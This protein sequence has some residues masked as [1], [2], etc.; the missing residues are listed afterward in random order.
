[1]KRLAEQYLKNWIQSENRK[2]LVLRGARQV[3]KSTLVRL[4]SQSQKLNLVEINLEKKKLKSIQSEDIFIE[5]VLAEIQAEYNVDIDSNSLVFFDEIQTQPEILKFLRYFYEEIPQIPIIAAGSL[6][7]FTLEEHE[8]SMPVGRV[9]YFHLGPMTF[10][11]FLLALNKSKLVQQV[12]K[13]KL[14]L[15]THVRSALSEF[16][17]EYL[18]VGGMPEAVASY[19]KFKNPT[20][21]RNIHRNIVRT[22]QDDFPKYAKRNNFKNIYQIFER[23]PEF[24]GKKI[25]YSEFNSELQSRDIRSCLQLLQRSRVILTCYHSNCSGIPLQSQEDENTFKIYFLDVGLLNYLKGA[26]WQM[27]QDYDEKQMITKGEVAEQFAAQHLAYIEEGLEKPNLIYW[28]RDKKIN[29][30]EVDFVIEKKSEIIP[31]EIKAGSSAR[32]QSAKQFAIE[33]KTKII[34]RYSL[35]KQDNATNEIMIETKDNQKQSLL[36]FNYHLASLGF[37]DS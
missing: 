28:L 18:F 8:F 2:P 30:A 29:N 32:L 14:N 27:L 10:E 20:K 15:D 13:D 1:M 5:K 22:Y 34:Y 9:E 37:C 3:G 31:I 11:E 12:K 4:F 25:K 36:V 6:L 7:E 21:V 33:H 35:G 26:S 23:L 16:L 24:I 17:K 19:I